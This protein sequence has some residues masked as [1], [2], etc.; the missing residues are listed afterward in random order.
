MHQGMADQKAYSNDDSEKYCALNNRK[1]HQD[2][3]GKFLWLILR[4]QS[5]S[6]REY[7]RITKKRSDEQNDEFQPKHYFTVYASYELPV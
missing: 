4:Y 2:W 7:S 1:Q 3:R 5:H 6:I